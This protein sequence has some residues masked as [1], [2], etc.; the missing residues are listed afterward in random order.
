MA[1]NT[2]LSNAAVNA[3]ADALSALLN[4]GYLRI[5]SGTQPATADTASSQGSAEIIV[6]AD[7]D[8]RQPKNR[9]KAEILTALLLA[10]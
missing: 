2:Q 10:A 1:K 8:D 4:T 3:E 7:L 9:R 6:L 5:Y